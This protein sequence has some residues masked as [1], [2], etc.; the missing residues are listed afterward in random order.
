MTLRSTPARARVRA[1]RWWVAAGVA[2]VLAIAT[3]ES[4]S[5]IAPVALAVAGAACAANAMRLEP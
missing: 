3:V 2:A 1:D 5:L 4:V